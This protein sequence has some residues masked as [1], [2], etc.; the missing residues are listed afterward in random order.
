MAGKKILAVIFA[1]LVLIKLA[2]LLIMP[3]QWLG[4]AQTFLGYSAASTAFYLIALIV[5]G[6]FIFTTMQ[7][8]RCGRGHAVHRP[9]DGSQSHPL[10]G[11]AATGM[12]QVAAAGHGQGLAAVDYLDSHRRGRALP[13]V[14]PGGVSKAVF[15]GEG[16]RVSGTLPFSPPRPPTPNAK[17]TAAEP[18]L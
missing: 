14:C 18:F 17:K 3:Q 4:M 8:H 11:V 2:F 6:Y 16:A 15:L 9:A 13:G 5:T 7:P 10:C 12:T 1:A